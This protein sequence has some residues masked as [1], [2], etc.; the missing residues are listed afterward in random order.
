MTKSIKNIFLA[1]IVSG[2]IA[3][4]G[5]CDKKLNVEPK[6]SVEIG[7][8]FKTEEEIEQGIIGCYSLMGA[9]A[10]YG[11]DLNLVSEL[12]G[13]YEYAEWFGTFSQYYDIQEKQMATNN[14]AAVRIWVAAYRVINLANVLRDKLTGPEGATIVSDADRRNELIGET[15]FIRGL[16]HFE[17]VRLYGNQYDATTLNTPGAVIKLNGAID[18][19]AAAEKPVRN[20]VAQTY[21][22]VIT[23][24]ESAAGKLPERNGVR[25]NKYTA[26]AFLS[27][28]FLQQGRYEK[29]LEAVNTVIG[30]G[31]YAAP[32]NDLLTPF[33]SKNSAEV[34]FEIQQNEQNNAGSAND[35][36][37]TFYADLENG[38]GRGDF[39]VDTN[40]IFKYPAGDK[41]V[42]AWYYIGYKYGSITT[43]KWHSYGQNIPIIRMAEMYLTRAECNIRLSS[44]VG[45]DPV[46]DL[47]RI[48]N[49]ERTGVAIIGSPTVEDVILQR[50]L[51][52]A[53]EG[54]N[55]HDLRRL[56]KPTGSFEWNDDLLVLPIPQRE[57]DAAQGRLEQN[58][59]YK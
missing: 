43:S 59:A 48:N 23:D 39:S 26:L 42:E 12:L 3:A 33:R 19:V 37:A 25:A 2:C 53:F 4:L 18:T 55:I 24:L 10:L 6:Q 11:T 14:D 27:R 54:L 28:V 17:L 49:P 50:R 56:R 9:A 32:S 22:Q 5:G 34:I 46:N 57:I 15:E 38:V 20:T 52:L 29:A 7:T 47:Q 40:F 30:E 16:L 35:G 1:F 36:L 58:A 51:E 41:R 8:T 21:T 44:S 31:G 45:D 13:A